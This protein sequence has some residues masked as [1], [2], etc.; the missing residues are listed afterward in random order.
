MNI[1][2]QTFT[3]FPDIFEG[4]KTP[5]RG[6]CCGCRPQLIGLYEGLALTL[7]Y[8]YILCRECNSFS[9]MSALSQGW[10]CLSKISPRL[11]LL[12]KPWVPASLGQSP[13]IGWCAVPGMIPEGSPPPPP[14][15]FLCFVNIK[16]LIHLCYV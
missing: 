16:L 15:L 4:P 6:P 2:K 1:H 11:K 8:H 3:N 5:N 7:T 9:S 12:Y 13:A 10:I 14:P